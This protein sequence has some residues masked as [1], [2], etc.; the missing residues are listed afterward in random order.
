MYT[1]LFGGYD[2][3]I[4]IPYYDSSCCD[5]I[6]FTDDE[7]LKS[8]SW[9]IRVVTLTL[10]AN[11]MNRMY[12]ILPHKFL[13]DYDGSLYIDANYVITKDLSG[14]IEENLED[15]NFIAMRHSERNCVYWEGLACVVE[16]KSDFDMVVRQ[17]VSYRNSGFPANYGLSNNSILLRS[18]NEPS[19][20]SLMNSW[21]AELN[22][23]TQ[24][25]QLS[26]QFLLWTHN[27]DIR[28]VD[29]AF[30]Q[31]NPY[32]RWVSHKHIK[33]GLRFRL[34]RRSR[35]FVRFVFFFPRFYYKILRYI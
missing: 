23:F 16:R 14:L 8:S 12:K 6:C 29:D 25:D 18:H 35:S 17:L 7:N 21:W 4:E 26:L 24:R 2:E 15:S 11:M 32:V 33:K 1:A 9:E 34:F 13:Q 10:A 3:L 27:V 5:Y 28:Y 30:V 20:I 19:L 22:K 31:P